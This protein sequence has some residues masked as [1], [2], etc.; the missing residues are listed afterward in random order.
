MC[1][2]LSVYQKKKDASVQEMIVKQFEEQL[3][4][5]KDGIGIVAYNADKKSGIVS[6]RDLF[7]DKSE[8]ESVLILR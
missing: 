2:I 4:T 8:V 6:F 3:K 7:V 5:N 1:V